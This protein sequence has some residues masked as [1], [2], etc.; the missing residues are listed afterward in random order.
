[1]SF[2]VGLLRGILVD[3]TGIFCDGYNATCVVLCPACKSALS[4]MNFLSSHMRRDHCSSM[5]SQMVFSNAQAIVM[6][7]DYRLFNV[8][9]SRRVWGDISGHS[10]ANQKCQIFSEHSV[11][12]S[13]ASRPY[14][15]S[16]AASTDVTFTRINQNKYNYRNTE[17][18]GH[19]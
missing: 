11:P 3:S 7:P 19:E 9:R 1:M 12:G 13:A 5:Q 2:T 8:R 15:L 14:A 6:M 18:I 10:C 4:R 16:S 17:Q